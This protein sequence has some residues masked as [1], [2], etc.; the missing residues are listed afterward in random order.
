MRT[1]ALCLVAMQKRKDNVVLFD[2]MGCKFHGTR[3]IAELYI[4]ERIGCG[5][6]L[7][8]YDTGTEHVHTCPGTCP[9]DLMDFARLLCCA[10]KGK[11]ERITSRAITLFPC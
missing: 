5:N 11:G 1:T 2:T 9:V 8:S 10:L 4:T 7:S 6:T 3:S